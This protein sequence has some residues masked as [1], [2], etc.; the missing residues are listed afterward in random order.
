M[1]R[2]SFSHF[3]RHFLRRL[4]P[5]ALLQRKGIPGL[6]TT[7]IR[8]TLHYLQQPQLQRIGQRPTCED[9]LPRLGG[10][11]ARQGSSTDGPHPVERPELSG[12]RAYFAEHRME[13]RR[14][15]DDGAPVAGALVDAPVDL[16]DDSNLARAAG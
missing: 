7:R 16:T 3:T 4:R 15:S 12:S 9:R 5:L 14:G 8:Q 11:R 13:Q 10:G 1:P 2:R 6:P